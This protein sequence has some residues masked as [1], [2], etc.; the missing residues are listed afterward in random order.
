[1]P[2]PSKQVVRPGR[3]NPLLAPLH[4]VVSVIWVGYATRFSSLPRFWE[5]TRPVDLDPPWPPKSLAIPRRWW[6]R[7]RWL[8]W[9]TRH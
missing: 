6:P 4:T 7:G 1:M 2:G 3:G 5:K 9:P 8:P